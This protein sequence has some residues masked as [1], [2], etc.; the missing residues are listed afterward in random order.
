M[1]K[2]L[3]TIT[4]DHDERD[5]YIL[6]IVNTETS[7]E[8]EYDRYYNKDDLDQA[9]Q[10]LKNEGLTENEQIE[11]EY[12]GPEIVVENLWIS[13][14]SET[15]DL[16]VTADFQVFDDEGDVTF[17]GSSDEYIDAD[18]GQIDT[19]NTGLMR[20]ETQWG[21]FDVNKVH[22]AINEVLYENPIDSS[23]LDDAREQSELQEEFEYSEH[24]SSNNDDSR[25]VHTDIYAA[26]YQVHVAFK[27]VS[28]EQENG[29]D[30]PTYSKSSMQYAKYDVETGSLKFDDDFNDQNSFN[31]KEIKSQLDR[32][33]ETPEAQEELQT[34]I[35][36]NVERR[37]IQEIGQSIAEGEAVVAS[38]DV[39]AIGCTLATETMFVVKEDEIVIEISS[40]SEVDLET[41]KSANTDHYDD[42]S[43]SPNSMRS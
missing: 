2:T 42:Y 5:N 9:V 16:I 41:G 14:Q 8:R 10:E 43:V 18:S 17:H 38:V 34:A 39:I 12:L 33:L 22:E 4:P 6:K 32:F 37:R 29:D 3:Q 24:R 13:K 19:Y 25:V 7:S 23:I 20:T 15:G 36:V 27:I 31:S 21:Y 11:T 35:D 26:D 40:I 1:S 30:F 28:K